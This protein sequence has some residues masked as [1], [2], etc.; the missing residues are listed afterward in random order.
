[1]GKTKFEIGSRW[2]S[3]SGNVMFQIVGRGSKPG[4][5]LTLVVCTNP[6]HTSSSAHSMLCA[7]GFTTEY[8]KKHIEKY[9]TKVEG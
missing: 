3:K 9:A 4:R 6:F 1:M 5:V 8:T 2:R 7:N